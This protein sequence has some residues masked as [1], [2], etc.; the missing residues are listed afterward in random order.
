MPTRT[1]ATLRRSGLIAGLGGLL[2]GCAMAPDGQQASSPAGSPLDIARQ[3]LQPRVV[4]TALPPASRPVLAPGDTFIY[5]RDH[6]VRLRTTTPDAWRWQAGTTTVLGTPDFF[7]PTWPDVHAGSPPQRVV[8]GQ[9][10]DLWP[11]EVGN[12]VS[13]TETR[14]TT[15][16]LTGRPT[17]TTLR[18]DCRVVDA[19]VSHVPAGDYD[20]FHVECRAYRAGLPVAVQIRTWDYSPAL[21]H[22]VRQTWLESGQRREQV[23]SAAL[24]AA[25]ATE[26]RIQHV[27]QRLAAP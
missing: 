1:L 23:L 21:G 18:W 9:P 16:G 11:L 24:P 19:R 14:G 7:V 15:A 2:A 26:T 5:G 8:L 10:G 12:T 17:S 4:R 25:V 20:S 3:I 27:L 6:V 22:V 13:F